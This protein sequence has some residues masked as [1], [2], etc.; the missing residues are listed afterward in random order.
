MVDL[1]AFKLYT[2]VLSLAV[3]ELNSPPRCSWNTAYLRRSATGV[4]EDP[5][6]RHTG[7]DALATG[8]RSSGT[9]G[10]RGRDRR[11]ASTPRRIPAR[12]EIRGS[13]RQWTTSD[14]RPTED[15]GERG[16]HLGAPA[17]AAPAFPVGRRARSSS[18]GCDRGTTRTWTSANQA[19][20]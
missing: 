3:G 6:A 7:R 19:P 1:I 14:I 12:V 8:R 17:I 5:R 2:K 13:P 20:Q 10:G 18:P 11:N 16:A 9:D 15:D 4:N